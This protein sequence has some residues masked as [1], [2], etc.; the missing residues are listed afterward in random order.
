MFQLFQSYFLLLE[1]GRQHDVLLL[2]LGQLVSRL[3]ALL[4]ESLQLLGGVLQLGLVLGLD[5]PETKF[6]VGDF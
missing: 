3:A 4:L 6:T 1:D 5:P 2:L